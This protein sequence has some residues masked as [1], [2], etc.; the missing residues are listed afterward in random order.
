MDRGTVGFVERGF[1]NI[2]QTQVLRCRDKSLRN[3]HRQI[4]AL[5]NV[6]ATDKAHRQLIAQ[7][8]ITNVDLSH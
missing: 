3:P 2:W 4:S 1:K 6:N 5:D 8:N 7:G